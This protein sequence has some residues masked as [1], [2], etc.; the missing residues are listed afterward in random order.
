MSKLNWEKL[1][2]RYLVK[3]KWAT[4]RVDCCRMPDGTLIDDYYVLEYPDWVNAVAVTEDNEVILI[5]QYR[6]A[7][8]EVI[9]EVPGGCIDPG[10][11]P[12]QA[13]KRELLEE[14]GYAFETL[15][16]MGWVY[17]NPSTSANKTHSY[18]LTGGKKVQEQHLDGREEIEVLKVSPDE[19]KDLVLNNKIPQALHV[20]AIF[21]GLVRLGLLK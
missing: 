20:T 11:T 3:E 13:V 6:H 5:R 21:N 9:L 19:L 7:A 18:L 1:S 2:S 4:L 17:A 15:E 8:E 16:P 10:E 12:E 14:T